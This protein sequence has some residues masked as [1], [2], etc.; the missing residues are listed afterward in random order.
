MARYGNSRTLP[1]GSAHYFVDSVRNYIP[2]QYL[3]PLETVLAA[4]DNAVA[5]EQE[6]CPEIDQIRME[7]LR[8]LDLTGSQ[9]AA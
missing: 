2:G 6:S 4:I 3:D 5:L 7:I 9:A 1:G 8:L